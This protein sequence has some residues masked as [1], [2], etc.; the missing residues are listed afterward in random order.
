VRSLLPLVGLVACGGGNGGAV[1]VAS[2]LATEVVFAPGD[3]GEGRFDATSAIDGVRGG[4][5]TAG[6]TDTFSLTYDEGAD[7]LVLG[8]GGARLLDGE[9]DDLVVFENPFDIASGGRFMDPTVV[10]LSP[11]G[12]RWVAFPH[13][14]DGDDVT[15]PSGWWGFAGVE[16]VVVHDDDRPMDYFDDDAGGDRFDLADLDEADPVA[17]EVLAEGAVAVR[18]SSAHLWTD[19]ATGEP[20]PRDPISDGADIDGIAAR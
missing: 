2:G 9:G 14:H 15:D 6:S 16:P 18:L 1:Q 13:G 12:E 20:F 17:A 3:Q 8:W 10:E 7:V 4:G 5:L 11:D 19:P